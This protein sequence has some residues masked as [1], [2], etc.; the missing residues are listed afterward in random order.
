WVPGSPAPTAPSH[1]PAVSYRSLTDCDAHDVP[2][3]RLQQDLDADALPAFVFITPNMCHSMHNCPVRTG[4]AW[5][6]KTMRA[7]LASSAYQRGTTAI[8][9]T[10]DEGEK[11]ST[12]RCAR[13]TSHPGCH[14]PIVVVSPSTLPGTRS[15]TLFNHYSLLRTTEEMLG[16]STYLGRA[17]TSSSMRA[18]FNL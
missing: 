4:D 16:V 1:T 6:G 8:F 7:L 9:V 11:G 14:V 12:D 17:S 10:F 2:F 15:A 13:N 18:A 3:A 5:L